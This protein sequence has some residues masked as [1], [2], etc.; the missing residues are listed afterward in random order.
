MVPSVVAELGPGSRLLASGPGL[1][2][3]TPQSRPKVYRGELGVDWP[4]STTS[5]LWDLGGLPKVSKPQAPHMR[6]RY[7]KDCGEDSVCTHMQTTQH[8]T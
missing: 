6:N 7:S 2:P 8:S 3:V 1:R 5:E 4:D